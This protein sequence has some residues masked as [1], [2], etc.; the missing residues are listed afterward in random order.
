MTRDT[1]DACFASLGVGAE[2]VTVAQTHLLS[3]KRVIFATKGEVHRQAQLV[4]VFVYGRREN[5]KLFL[6]FH[7][8][9][10]L[11]HQDIDVDHPV[12]VW[13]IPHFAFLP[14]FL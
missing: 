12:I 9:Q 14:A 2:K 10:E 1:A 6:R 7:Q 5:L 13:E 4:A 3:N 8:G 11:D